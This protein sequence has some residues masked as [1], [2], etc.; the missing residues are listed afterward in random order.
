MS[1]HCDLLVIGSGPAGQKAAIQAAKGGMQV[2]VCEQLREIG[3][4]CVQYGTIPS[5]SLRERAMA[6]AAVFASGFVDQQRKPT[7]AN[8]NVAELIGEMDDILRA[9]DCYMTEQLQ[10]NGIELLHGRA[11][12]SDTHTAMVQ[13]NK[14]QDTEVA[15]KHAL[16]ATG[17]TPRQ[18][19]NVP[20]DHEHI[21]DS[22]SILNMAYLPES[23]VVLGGGVIACEYASIFALLGVKVT[24][25]DR[26]AR[27]LGFLDEELTD[28]FLE[29]FASFNGEFIGERELLSVELNDL[30][31]VV[32]HLHGEKA[33]ESDKLLCAL[34][35]VSTLAGLGCEAIGIDVT[36]RD[37]VAVNEHGQ[38]SLPH[39][40]AAGDAV[41]P[42]AL[43]SASM[44]QG[45]RAAR[46]M[47]GLDSGAG[48]GLVPTGIYAVPELSCVG[49]TQTQAEA[50]G[51][52]VLVGTARFSEVARG[53]IADAREGLLKM[54]ADRSG[55]LLGIHI[56]GPQ[57]TEL[58][59]IGQMAL[60]HEAN[61]TLFIDNVFNFP[62]YAEAY[63]V[64][65]LTIS[66]QVIKAAEKTSGDDSQAVA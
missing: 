61:I 3:G 13:N 58:V 31:R 17:S 32:T 64:A 59:H 25:L 62:T 10:R 18:P 29:G 56:V 8:T 4:A 37:H 52:D 46:H 49:L 42:P 45:R 63:R 60:L 34:G 27:P 11:R 38:T 1:K 44:E 43:A 24:I 57:A 14:G 26:Y 66:G 40:Y 6:R 2:I 21:L 36:E 51:H 41:G 50:A 55:R 47:L 53:H 9:H 33:I 16:I 23:L 35:R 48:V 15:F 5:K 54:V 12:F 30:G 19:D 65:A 28:H 20:I 22:D 39:I 7:L